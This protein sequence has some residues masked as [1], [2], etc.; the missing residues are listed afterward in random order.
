MPCAGIPNAE[1]AAKIEDALNAQTQQQEEEE[2]ARQEGHVKAQ[3]YYAYGRAAGWALMAVLAVSF[4]LM[5]V[6][7]R[8]HAPLLHGCC[9]VTLTH[10][11]LPGSWALMA[12]LA[13]SFIL[14]RIMLRNHAAL[15]HGCCAVTLTHLRLPDS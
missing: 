9:A 8:D 7:L 10:L 4:I 1:S 2:E 11:R 14:M 6:M 12:E 13:P 3:V 5:Q 15:L